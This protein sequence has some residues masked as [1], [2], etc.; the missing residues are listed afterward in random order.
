MSY[1]ETEAELDFTKDKVKCYSKGYIEMEDQRLILPTPRGEVLTQF[2][3]GVLVFKRSDLGHENRIVLGLAGEYGGTSG[4]REMTL[5][6]LNPQGDED[7]IP[8]SLYMDNDTEDG[9]YAGTIEGRRNAKVKKVGEVSLQKFK[10]LD[11][12]VVHNKG[13]DKFIERCLGECKE[14]PRGAKGFADAYL[15]EKQQL[16]HESYLY[17]ASAKIGG[18]V[19]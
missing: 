1:F 10:K 17:L 16:I 7:E 12:E 13:I 19:I 4:E 8:L 6:I 15:E 9:S 2:L 5:Y 3:H 14:L 18:H 11:K